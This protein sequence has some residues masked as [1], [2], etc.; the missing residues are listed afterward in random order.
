MA[1]L[2]PDQRK[3]LARRL[4]RDFIAALSDDGSPSEATQGAFGVGNSGGI[5]ASGGKPVGQLV[6]AAWAA[7]FRLK[8]AI[9]EDSL[10]AALLAGQLPQLL[11]DKVTLHARDAAA[12]R[13]FPALAELAARGL[14][15]ISW[16]QR[17][18]AVVSGIPRGASSPKQQKQQQQQRPAAAATTAGAPGRPQGAAPAA[19]LAATAAAAPAVAVQADPKQ[20]TGRY[21]LLAGLSKAE[22]NGAVGLCR[23]FDAAAGRY[24]VVLATPPEVAKAHPNGLKVK[25]ENLQEAPA[26]AAAAARRARQ[27]QA[28][29]VTAGSKL[30]PH[31]LSRA[32]AAACAALSDDWRPCPLPAL[33]GVPLALQR[34]PGGG[35]DDDDAEA[36]PS[37]VHVG[38]ELL[39]DPKSGYPPMDVLSRGMPSCVVARTD[40]RNLSVEELVRKPGNQTCSLCGRRQAPPGTLRL[41]W[42][43]IVCDAC[44]ARAQLALR[45]L[46]TRLVDCYRATRGSAVA[47]RR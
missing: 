34:V 25:P 46:R 38:A 19:A 24:A 20:L 36:G 27:Q 40:G 26:A 15:G 30:A 5:P 47:Q 11:R 41:F 37:S 18:H 17:V 29:L 4:S 3:A 13:R 28:V 7:L 8:E 35:G 31:P 39:V 21:V 12:A 9:N 14:D 43:S 1:A 44:S 10:E 22:L 16:D 23:G 6:L 32:D 42:P 33:A 2:P 45:A